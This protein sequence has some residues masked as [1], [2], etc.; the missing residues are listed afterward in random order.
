[1]QSVLK[2]ARCRRM[3]DA[4]AARRAVPCVMVLLALSLLAAVH[5][6]PV[7]TSD[8]CEMWASSGE[9]DANPDYMR[10]NC[11]ATCERVAASG[12]AAGDDGSSRADAITCARWAMMGFC[13]ETH[14]HAAFMHANCADACEKAARMGEA[15]PPPFDLWV[16][17]LVGGFGTLVLYAARAAIA[18]DGALSATVQRKT[19]GIQKGVGPG[20]PNRSAM[21]KQVRSAKKAS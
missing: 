16:V 2:F 9:C 19:L 3:R 12:G 18:R 11:A 7:D 10:Q 17:L 5:A 1:M 14:T 20:K 4:I 13:K 21:H 6:V 15:K 8:M